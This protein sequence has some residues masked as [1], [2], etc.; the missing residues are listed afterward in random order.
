MG[1]PTFAPRHVGLAFYS[2][3]FTPL[4][5]LNQLDADLKL[6]WTGYADDI[7]CYE[8][9][10]R[11]IVVTVFSVDVATRAATVYGSRESV[12]EVHD[13]LARSY[14]RIASHGTRSLLRWC[15]NYAA[16]REEQLVATGQ[17]HALLPEWPRRL[18]KW[19]ER[20]K[21]GPDA[22]L[23]HE[24]SHGFEPPPDGG[25]SLDAALLKVSTP[26][27]L[28]EL[29]SAIADL[30]ALHFTPR[31]LVQYLKLSG[32]IREAGKVETILR[33]IRNERAEDINDG[34]EHA[35]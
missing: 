32:H 24:L 2:S 1:M 26:S 35:D 18:D 3:G 4:Q 5:M 31:A 21:K 9:G 28:P 22:I 6:E 19:W 10:G 12:N 34:A 27:G 33:K 30:A 15:A 8:A 14:R 29:Y 25:P 16:D 11:S 20:V 17:P 7:R 13:R 23:D